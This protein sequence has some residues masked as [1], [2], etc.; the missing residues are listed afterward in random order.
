MNLK[1][2]LRKGTLL[3]EVATGKVV[4]EYLIKFTTNFFT[5]LQCKSDRPGFGAKPY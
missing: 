5:F 4:G 1:A 2:L 3:R